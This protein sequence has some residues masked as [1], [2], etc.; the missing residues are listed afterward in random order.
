M[1]CE[2]PVR[3]WCVVRNSQDIKRL[4][5]ETWEEKHVAIGRDARNV[6]HKKIEVT[7]VRLVGNEHLL[8]EYEQQRSII[9]TRRSRIRSFS[10]PLS[11]KTSTLSMNTCINH[12]IVIGRCNLPSLSAFV[13]FGVILLGNTLHSYK[14]VALMA[15]N[16]R[17]SG[18][19][20]KH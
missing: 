13:Y 6:R 10:G 4:V 5:C 17:F 7:E 14:R 19:V 11:V 16:W 9:R 3:Y 15:V 18:V 2:K 20:I 8:M 1:P 12:S